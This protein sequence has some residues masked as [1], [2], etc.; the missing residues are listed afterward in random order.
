MHVKSITGV[1]LTEVCV[2][3]GY[4][5][6]GYKGDAVIHIAGSKSKSR[7]ARQRKRLK[8]RNAIEP[9]IGHLKFE[10]RMNRCFLKGLV[11]DAVNALLAA[12]ASNMQKI[13]ASMSYG[14]GKKHAFG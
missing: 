10:N 14:S 12:A 4:R 7:T 11:G 6:H 13:L 1:S 9:K 8:R 3:K 2:D 5:G